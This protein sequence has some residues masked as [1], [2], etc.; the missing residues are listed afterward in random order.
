M[1]MF[2]DLLT[3]INQYPS[4]DVTISVTDFEEPGTHI[5]VG[6]TCRFRVRVQNNGQLDMRDVRLHIE[7]SEFASV[8]VTNFLGTPLG[9][10]SSVVSGGRNIDAHS[11]ATFGDFHIRADAATPNAGTADRDLFTIHIRS[12]DA[13]LEHIFRDHRH[14]AGS[15]EVAYNRHIHPA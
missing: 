8:T 13:G 15:P 4:E 2:D 7:G 12:F 14:H 10:S 3:A 5:N 1:G 6:E 9:F 11:S